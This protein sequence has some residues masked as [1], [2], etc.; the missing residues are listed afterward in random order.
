MLIMNEYEHYMLVKSYV[1]YM[2][3]IRIKRMHTIDIF[4]SY[5]STFWI[6]SSLSTKYTSLNNAV[7][8]CDTRCI[9]YSNHKS[10][11]HMSV[12]KVPDWSAALNQC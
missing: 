12:P 6:F 4:C 10:A 5:L 8:G 3:V 2:L 1:L 9:N 7:N 11:M